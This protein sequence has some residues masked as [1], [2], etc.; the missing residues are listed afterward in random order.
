MKTKPL[1]T[2]WKYLLFFGLG[3][4]LVGF[5]LL[6]FGATAGGIDGI[7]ANT[8]AKIT[9]LTFDHVKAID[10]ST[11]RDVTIQGG[12]VEKVT[13][14]YYNHPKFLPETEVTQ[15]GDTLNLSQNSRGSIITGF[16]EAGGYV[17]NE[18]QSRGQYSQ[19]TIT[20]PKDMTI[21]KLSG[22]FMSLNSALVNLTINEINTSGSL[23][24]IVN[25]T[26]KSGSLTGIEGAQVDGSTLTNLTFEHLGSLYISDSQLEN[27]QFPNFSSH[28]SADTSTFKN[29]SF[30]N[31]LQETY[32][33]TTDSDWEE[34][35]YYYSYGVSLSLADSSIEN[36]TFK[37]AGEISGRNLTLA[38]NI[39]ISGPETVVDLG[40]T[41][42]SRKHTN[43]T[44]QT[45]N[46][47]I[48]LDHQTDH[49]DI[50]TK[51]ESSHYHKTVE[52]PKAELIINSQYG[53]IAIH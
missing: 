29:I 42:D 47:T 16:M 25:T 21:D 10:V 20:V 3:S 30:D 34:E 43:L 6:S 32:P 41:T 50:V 52:N 8:K 22:N 15:S 27:I 4:L 48:T 5:S 11:F 31:A 53:S 38:G 12:D 49:P 44:L 35:T 18:H 2:K 14:T 17:L 45:A 28:L 13:V 37:G 23:G 33:D 1:S 9:T 46:G 36:L 40:L 39:N 51:E 19:I 26:I 7:K 24:Y